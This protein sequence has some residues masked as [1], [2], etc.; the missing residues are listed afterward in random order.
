MSKVVPILIHLDSDLLKRLSAVY[1]KDAE[2]QGLPR[3]P[4]KNRSAFIRLAI[5]D[6]VELVEKRLAKEE[7]RAA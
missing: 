1:P 3:A 7:G 4:K 5:R 6:R 2:T